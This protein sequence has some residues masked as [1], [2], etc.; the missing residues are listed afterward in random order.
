M[1]TVPEHDQDDWPRSGTAG[2]GRLRAAL[3]SGDSADPNRG[4][5]AG[6]YR[7]PTLALVGAPVGRHHEKGVVGPQEQSDQLL[8]APDATPSSQE[9]ATQ[10]SQA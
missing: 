7:G 6:R 3:R 5:P 4:H 8:G 2:A 9:W 1:L 10:G